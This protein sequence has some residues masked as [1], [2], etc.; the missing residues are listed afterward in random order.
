MLRACAALP[1][2]P[3]VLLMMQWTHGRLRSEAYYVFVA[4]LGGARWVVELIGALP[5]MILC[6]QN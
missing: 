6:D 4:S 2:W 5:N 3:R 1:S